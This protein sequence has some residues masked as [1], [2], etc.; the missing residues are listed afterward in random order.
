VGRLLLV[1]VLAAGCASIG[2]AD[3]S[4]GQQRATLVSGSSNES[5][6][7]ELISLQPE[8]AVVSD[9]VVTHLLQVTWPP[10]LAAKDVSERRLLLGM[11]LYYTSLLWNAASGPNPQANAI[12]LEREARMRGRHC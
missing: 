4:A 11:R 2:R 10:L 6:A 12:R 9:S 8:L 1:L 7:R 3:R 5:A